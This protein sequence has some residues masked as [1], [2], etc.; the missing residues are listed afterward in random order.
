MVPKASG[1]GL[2]GV[3]VRT[4]LRQ[5]GQQRGEVSCLHFWGSYCFEGVLLLPVWEGPE[6]CGN[7]LP[8]E[9]NWWKS[10]KRPREVRPF[11]KGILFRFFSLQNLLQFQENLFGKFRL[12]SGE[13][14]ARNLYTGDPTQSL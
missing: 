3:L 6:N 2:P 1:T 4:L 11:G 8:T 14:S 9:I 5:R 7:F 10:K 13:K 12:E